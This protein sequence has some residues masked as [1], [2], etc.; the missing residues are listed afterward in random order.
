MLKE[1][2]IKINGKEQGPFTKEELRCDPRIS[3]YTLVKKLG[4]ARWRALYDVPELRDLFNFFDEE[5]GRDA[6][7]R[8]GGRGASEA[9]LA[10]QLDPGHFYLFLLIALIILLFV[11]FRAMNFSQ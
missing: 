11:F 4:W 8:K 6:K 1:W 9:T 2:F 7:K 10:V 3:P 5:E